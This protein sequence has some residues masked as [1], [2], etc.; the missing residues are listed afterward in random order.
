MGY[1]YCFRLKLSDALVV[2]DSGGACRAIGAGENGRERM[3]CCRRKRLVARD[4]RFLL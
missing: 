2:S 3:F 4:E 1:N